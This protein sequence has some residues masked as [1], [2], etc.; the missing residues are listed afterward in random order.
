MKLATDGFEM[1]NGNNCLER[2]CLCVMYELATL[3]LAWKTQ[4]R[5]ERP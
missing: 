5:F 2:V 1:R 3:H 4:R